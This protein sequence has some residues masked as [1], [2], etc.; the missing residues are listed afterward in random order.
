MNQMDIKKQRPFLKW[1]GGKFNCL[2]KI[3]LALPKGRRLIEPFLGSGTVFMNTQYSSYLLAETNNDLISIFSILQTQGESFIHFCKQFFTFETNSKTKYYEF[4]SEFNQLQ[5]SEKRA[6]LFLYLNRHGYN[7][8]CRYNSKGIYNV[9]F[10][11]YDKPYFP[12]KEMISFYNKCQNTE[13]I[14]KDFRETFKLAEK[15]DII[16]CDPP[17]V[18]IKE[19]AQPLHYTKKVFSNEDQIELAELAREASNKGISVLISN[20]DTEFTRK[21]YKPAKIESFQVARFISCQKHN[22]QPVRELVA[23]FKARRS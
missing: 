19:S 1:A 3:I 21:H 4:R 12:Q 9:P 13:F 8:L 10:G 17:Y 16:Y 14:H 5:N 20:H 15:G 23:T 6:A 18:P 7:G 2:D 11:L 22:R